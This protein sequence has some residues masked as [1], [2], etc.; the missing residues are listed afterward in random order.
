MQ[1]YKEEKKT[2]FFLLNNILPLTLRVFFIF[3]EPDTDDV[4]AQ[5]HPELFKSPF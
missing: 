3:G 2:L 4:Q 1:Q 5:S